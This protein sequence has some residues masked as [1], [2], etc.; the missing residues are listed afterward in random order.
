MNCNL[1]SLSKWNTVLSRFST[2]LVLI[3]SW[4]KYTIFTDDR[5]VTCTVIDFEPQYK[6]NIDINRNSVTTV[7]NISIARITNFSPWTFSQ[8]QQPELTKHLRPSFW[9]AWRSAEC[10][11]PSYRYSQTLTPCHSIVTNSNCR[12]SKLKL[13]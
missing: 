12:N 7:I 2:A 5:F 3:K 13:N 9:T 1:T 8:R 11:T 6:K 10:L 4:N